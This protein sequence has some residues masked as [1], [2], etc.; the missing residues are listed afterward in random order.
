VF[1]RSSLPRDATL[2]DAD[3]WVLVGDGYHSEQEALEDGERLQDALTI[4][5]ARLRIGVNL[6]DRSAKGQFTDLGLRSLEASS[7]HR[8]LNDV[9]DRNET[10]H[11]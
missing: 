7:G 4:A 6:G 9:T 5:L 2:K 10:S 8:V 11:E 3:R 1:L